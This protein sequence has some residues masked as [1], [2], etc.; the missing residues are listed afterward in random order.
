M[1]YERDLELYAEK[2]C[3][4]SGCRNRAVYPRR[5]CRKHIEEKASTF[6]KNPLVK[7]KV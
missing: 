6:I 3:S 5:L 1:V 2:L 4:R 7:Y